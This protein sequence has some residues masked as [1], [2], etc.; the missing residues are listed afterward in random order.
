MKST[1]KVA[2]IVLVIGAIGIAGYYF[3]SSI[4]APPPPPPDITKFEHHIQQRVKEEI[5][6]R[7]F[8]E[9]TTSYLSILDE[10]QTE[11]AITLENGEKILSGR[12]EKKCRKEAFYAYAPILVEYATS[13]FRKTEWNENTIDSLKDYAKDLLAANIAE[14]STNIEQQLNSTIKIVNDYYEAKNVIAGSNNCKSLH[15]VDNLISRARNLRQVPLTNNTA[16]ANGLAQVPE[17]AKRSFVDFVVR[18]CNNVATNYRAYSS[19]SDFYRECETMSNM[20]E[21]YREKY[22]QNNLLKDA[23]D[24]LSIADSKALDYYE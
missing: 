5:E 18:R 19:Y 22:G 16:I 15:T 2:L 23:L 8:A 24:V 12:E 21:G 20:I 9:A 7:D 4:G 1:I 17:K 10:I 11:A 13:Y 14:T 6:E 3:L